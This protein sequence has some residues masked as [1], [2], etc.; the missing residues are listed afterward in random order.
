[1]TSISNFQVFSVLTLRYLRRSFTDYTVFVDGTRF[2]VHK[3]VLACHSGYFADVFTQQNFQ[4]CAITSSMKLDDCFGI[5]ASVFQAILD[6]MYS[7]SEYI[8]CLFRGS[9]CC[10]LKKQ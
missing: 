5:T 4:S 7:S 6:Y 3:A 9:A 2:D 8:V 1:M 10:G